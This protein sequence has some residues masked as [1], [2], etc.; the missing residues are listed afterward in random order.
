MEDK[1]IVNIDPD[2]EDLIPTFLQNRH[3]DIDSMRTALTEDNFDTIRIIGHSMKGA[4][5]G[6]GFDPITEIGGE[7]EHAA[8]AKDKTVIEAGVVKLADYLARIV[9]SFD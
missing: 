4:G 9:V 3:N 7:I 8:L 1:I 5:G 6:Y 2:L